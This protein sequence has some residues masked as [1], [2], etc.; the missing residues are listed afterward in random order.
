MLPK[1]THCQNNVGFV[2]EDGNAVSHAGAAD[3]LVLLRDNG[4]LEGMKAAKGDKIV[5]ALTQIVTQ[6]V[7]HAGGRPQ[8]R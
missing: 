8:R 6:A 3:E 2:L 7:S 5:L 1:S 4:R